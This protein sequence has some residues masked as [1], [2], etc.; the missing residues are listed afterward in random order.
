MVGEK[1]RDHPERQTLE[2]IC[3]GNEKKAKRV[4]RGSRGPYSWP[5]A[6]PLTE[7]SG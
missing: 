2:G 6:T 1:G 5:M 7:D 3:V 4:A